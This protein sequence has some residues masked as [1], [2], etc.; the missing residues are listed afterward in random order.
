MPPRSGRSRQRG[1]APLPARPP[2]KRRPLRPSRG[3]SPAPA[4]RPS[5]PRQPQAHRAPL[6]DLWIQPSCPNPPRRSGPAR[7]ARH[8][9]LTQRVTSHRATAAALERGKGTGRERRASVGGGAKARGRGRTGRGQGEGAGPERCRGPTLR[10]R[11]VGFRCAACR[12]CG[13]RACPRRPLP[14]APSASSPGSAAAERHRFWGVLAGTERRLLSQIS[15]T[16]A[17]E[18]ASSALTE[19]T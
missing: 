16:A 5:S 19:A 11:P 3:A 7:N 1:F 8:F 18:R 9:R 12:A 14:L 13:S 15:V 17:S 6:T 10:A 4:Q 2:R